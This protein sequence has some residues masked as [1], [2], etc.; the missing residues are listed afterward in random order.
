MHSHLIPGIDDGA[1]SVEDAIE[2]I[3][4]LVGLGYKKIIT[5][6]HIM[7]EY[8]PNTPAIISS[9]LVKLKRG[10][11]K[12]NI[13]VEIE[14]AAEYYLD[15]SFEN[16]LANDKQLLV[17]SEKYVLVEFSTIARPANV[18]ETIFQLKTKGYQPILAHPERY[19]YYQEEKD[20]FEKF[21][22]MGCLF[23][24]NLLSLA[25]YYGRAQ[26]KLSLKFLETGWVDFLGTDLHRISQ[27][28]QLQ[29]VLQD[30][31]MLKYFDRL[32]FKNIEI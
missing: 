9:G 28:E 1:K 24:V 15:D 27:V 26:K 14:A 16:L 31:K 4:A 11:E 7:T 6:P 3:R 13:D 20:A 12:E 22:K 8:Y 17:I 21:R 25:G 10:L 18:Y 23:Q 29:S 5:T 32:K 30:K 19:L 2:M